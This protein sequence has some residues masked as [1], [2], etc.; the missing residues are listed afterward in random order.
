MS[1]PT[2]TAVDGAQSQQRN[3]ANGGMRNRAQPD[4][5]LGSHN[6]D[7]SPMQSY[8]DKLAFEL[9]RNLGV[10]VG[11]HFYHNH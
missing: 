2:S 11:R 5:R 4:L 3:S 1:K 8:P 9:A 10:S 6:M 7:C